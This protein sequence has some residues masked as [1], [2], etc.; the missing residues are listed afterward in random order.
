MDGSAAEKCRDIIEAMMTDVK[1]GKIYTGRIVSIKDFGAFVEIAPETD[2]LVHVSELSNHYVD[3][4]TDVVNV[5]DE[6][7][8]KV[9]L[10]DEQ[11]TGVG[12]VNFDNRSFAINFELTLWFTHPQ[13]IA[14]V[15]AMLTIDLSNSRPTT[16]EEL[17][18]VPFYKRFLWQAAKL[19]SP[20][21]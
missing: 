16:L 7:Q 4:V 21:L 8:V 15:E 20:M 11:I 12:T 6:V 14:D 5:G 18:A 9:I 1:I 19:F 13:M 2:G 17:K 10:I 3:R